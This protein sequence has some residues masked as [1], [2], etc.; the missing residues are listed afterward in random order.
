VCGFD[1]PAGRQVPTPGLPADKQACLPIGRYKISFEK[2]T[3]LFLILSFNSVILKYE[4]QTLYLRHSTP[5][6]DIMFK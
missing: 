1:L 6:F 3:F 5:F 2:K 4:K